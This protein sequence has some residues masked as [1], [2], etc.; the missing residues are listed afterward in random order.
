MQRS[1]LTKLVPL[2]LVVLAAGI[3]P[4]CG[5]GNIAEPASPIANA[6]SEAAKKAREQDEQLRL[7]RSKEEAKAR[8]R[9]KGLPE[10]G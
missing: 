3:L 1:I 10:E 4:G 6:E 8:K 5:S 9:I 2:L 7:L